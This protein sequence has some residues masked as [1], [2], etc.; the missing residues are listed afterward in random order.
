[1][2]GRL[3]DLQLPTDLVEALAFTEQRKRAL[4]F[5]GQSADTTNGKILG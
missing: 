4:S 2:P 3:G 5:G 1:V